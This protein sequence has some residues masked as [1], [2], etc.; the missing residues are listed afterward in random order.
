MNYE[1][2]YEHLLLTAKETIK[3]IGW[4][5]IFILSALRP[6]QYAIKAGEGLRQLKE[7]KKRQPTLQEIEEFKWEGKEA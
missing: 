2:E 7:E 6:L 5:K 3:R 4:R 1:S